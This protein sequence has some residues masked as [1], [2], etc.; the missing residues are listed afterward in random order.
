[1]TIIK[2]RG[3]QK[4]TKKLKQLYLEI[5]IGSELCGIASTNLGILSTRATDGYYSMS[6]QPCWENPFFTINCWNEKS[7]NK[8]R[9]F[10]DLVIIFH[11]ISAQR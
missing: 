7:Q 4:P 2:P 11:Q 6:N 5:G 8:S 10:T 1:M 9:R 3:Q